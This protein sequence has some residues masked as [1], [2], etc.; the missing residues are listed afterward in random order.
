M[1]TADLM[2]FFEQPDLCAHIVRSHGG[3]Q[4]RRSG[5]KDDDVELRHASVSRFRPCEVGRFVALLV[6]M[7]A[8]GLRAI[9]IVRG[10]TLGLVIRRL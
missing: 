8:D 3:G 7:P 2:E 6:Y 1:K 4:S 5:A 9:E 10:W